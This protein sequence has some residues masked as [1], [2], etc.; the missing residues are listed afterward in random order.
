[1]LRRGT[2][3]NVLAKDS[4]GVVEEGKDDIERLEIAPEFVVQ[5][6]AAR[7]KTRQGPRLDRVEGVANAP[8][9]CQPRYVRVA[10]DFQAGLGELLPKRCHHW[11]GQNEIAKGTATN[12]ENPSHLSGRRS[13]ARATRSRLLLP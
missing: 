9:Q 2:T 7:E 13:D 3:R 5:R 11:Q 4:V 12:D 6:A 1:E 10:Q 8:M